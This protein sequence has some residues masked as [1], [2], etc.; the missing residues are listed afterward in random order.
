MPSN[1]IQAKLNAVEGDKITLNEEKDELNKE[2]D[3]LQGE[4]RTLQ[5]VNTT[6]Q[7]EKTRLQNANTTLQGEMTTLQGEMTTLQGEMT[8]L[9]ETNRGLIKERDT[10]EKYK[11]DALKAFYVTQESLKTCTRVLYKERSRSKCLEE[12]SIKTKTSLN[13]YHNS[14][15]TKANRRLLRKGGTAI[16]SFFPWLGLLDVLGDI[17]E[18]LEDTSAI[19]VEIDDISTTIDGLSIDAFNKFVDADKT[20]ETADESFL[21]SFEEKFKDEIQELNPE[22]PKETFKKLDTSDID[23]FVDDSI[24]DSEYW[25]HLLPNEDMDEKAQAALIEDIF[26][27]AENLVND[28]IDNHRTQKDQSE[29]SD[30]EPQATEEANLHQIFIYHFRLLFYTSNQTNAIGGSR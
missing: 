8:T 25:N 24:K 23:T 13:N 2:K 7:K 19:S 5:N 12:I 30:V 20:V 26:R 21:N 11:E 1:G 29:E 18:I 6:F 22:N 10:E 9:K 27:K 3:E 15:G 28:A 4:I 17:G 16:L 14:V